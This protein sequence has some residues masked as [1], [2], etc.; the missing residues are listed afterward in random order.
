MNA[1]GS[2]GT[3]TTGNSTVWVTNSS[4]TSLTNTSFSGSGLIG[5]TVVNGNTLRVVQAH[6]D[7]SAWGHDGPRRLD[8][9]GGVLELLAG[10]GR[11]DFPDGSKVI[12]DDL[13]NYVIEDKD[14]KVKY[15]AN[16]N[17]EFNRYVNASELLSQFVRELGG[18][19]VTQ[20][21]VLNVPIEVFVNWL[22]HRAAD[23][24]GDEYAKRG[25]PTITDE[26]HLLPRQAR[27]GYCQRFLSKKHE[28]LGMRHCNP[29]HMAKHALRVGMTFE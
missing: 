16:F 17:R 5:T 20:D 26:K 1:N 13:G 28:T 7:T 3:Y 8:D 29:D 18:V 25:V 27:C 14:A 22:V 19:G 21:K 24:D 9:F 10:A 11:I 4:S 12:M 23:A 6:D 15:K 2:I